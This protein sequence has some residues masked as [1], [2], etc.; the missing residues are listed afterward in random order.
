[1]IEHVVKLPNSL[2]KDVYISRL[3]Q[4]IYRLA[5]G[6]SIQHV[7]VD[8]LKLMKADKT[9][10]RIVLS[11]KAGEFL[12]VYKEENNLT[13]IDA[14]TIALLQI[15]ENTHLYLINEKEN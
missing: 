13:T 9:S 10:T 11:K 5:Y 2:R 6:L 8:A 7:N 15:K 14:M 4:S 12:E 1:M 3:E